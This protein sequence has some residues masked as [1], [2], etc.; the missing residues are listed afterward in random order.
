[1]IDILAKVL[2]AMVLFTVDFTSGTNRLSW[3]VEQ[4]VIKTRKYYHLQGIVDL[5]LVH[6][7][8]PCDSC[9]WQIMVGYDNHYHKALCQL[10]S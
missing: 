6:L 10:H 3:G 9:D 7:I 2:P 4:N 8:G 1:M 5:L